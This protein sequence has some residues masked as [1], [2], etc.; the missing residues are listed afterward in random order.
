MAPLVGHF[1]ISAAASAYLPAMIGYI[2][3][4]KQQNASAPAAAVQASMFV[5]AGVLIYASVA[6]VHSLGFGGFFTL[7]AGIEFACACSAAICLW[8]SFRKAR[9][10]SAAQ[11]QQPEDKESH[12]I[13]IQVKD[14]PVVKDAEQ[15]NP[16]TEDDVV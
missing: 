6:G 10:L 5:I 4:I 2:S 14:G 3:T 1:V 8:G 15:A 13:D 7:M 11:Q 16:G 12:D 9:M